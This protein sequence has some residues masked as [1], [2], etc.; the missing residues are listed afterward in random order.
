MTN[1]WTDIRNTD[2]VLAMGGNPA[3][4]HPCGFKW[5]I[6]AKK[7]RRAKLVSVDPRFNRTSA[8]A[9]VYVPI[10]AGT[11]IA[12]LGGLIHH[13]ISN[14]KIHEDYVKLHT[15]ALFLL[16]PGSELGPEGVFGGFDAAT[17][18]YDKSKWKYSLDEKGYAKRAASLDD[19]ACVFQHLKKHFSRYTPE[20][21]AD[22]C[23]CTKEDFLRAA[24]VVNSTGTPDRAGTM[25]YALGWTHHSTSVQIIRA[26]AILQLLLGNIGRA[27]GGVNALRGHAN[28]Q[29]GTDHGVA[30]HSLAGYLKMPHPADTTIDKY[31]ERTTPK[32]LSATSMNYYGNTPKFLVS[33]LKAIYGRNATKE[34]EWGFHWLPKV[35]D[36]YSWVYLFDNMY[37]GKIKGFIDFGMNPVAN[38]PNTEKMIAALARLD[39]CV[40][41]EAF[42]TET[43]DF[44]K[45]TK[46]PSQTEVFLLPAAIFAEKDGSF[47][48]SSR[49]AQWKHKA[50][51]PPGSA[52]ADQEILARLFVRVRE[53]YAKEGGPGAESIS[54]LDWSYK[55]PYDPSLEEIAKEI[56]GRDLGTGK[57][58]SS[59]GE[60]KADGTTA[61]GNWIYSG[62]FTEAGNMMARRDPRDP[63]GLGR[64][65]GWAWNWPANRRVLYNRAGADAEGKPWDPTR[66]GIQWDG[67]KWIGDVPDMKPDAKPGT[68][69]AFVMLPEGVAKL[70]APDFMDGPFPEHYEAQE[71][72]VDNPLHPTYSS[73][74][75]AHVFKSALDPAFGD[76]KVYDIVATTFRL[77]EHFHY[78]TKHIAPNAALQ[79]EFFVEIP[80]GLAKE[81]QIANED[82]VR[83]ST[84]RGSIEGRALV[85]RRLRAMKV[86]GK[87]VWQVAIPIHWGFTGRAGKGVGRG[88]M[89][90]LLTPSVVDPNSHTPEYKTFLVKL[91]KVG[92]V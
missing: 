63:S 3:E 32:P 86:T 12:F 38:G 50:C 19:P 72:P 66:S 26:A 8:V 92:S 68:L 83:L 18:K 2:V 57:Q 89:A 11:D 41:A 84:P 10:R 33:L 34:N 59:F 43:A 28:I 45:V 15:N 56:N 87:T 44:W 85:T 82:R 53:L 22:I 23:G 81:R 71:H 52:L 61:C 24:E 25:M 46:E 51:D 4:N 62:S 9:D 65:E 54:N 90:N 60:L 48:N 6:E 70:W 88:P 39:W 27:G 55:N 64:Y 77:T 47:S 76:P 40:I 31:L 5:V 35:A 42:E 91:E 73:N 30:Y 1:G 80:E 7:K 37:A 74:P 79:P 20:V 67:D 16:E 78:W 69:D 49:W 21:V 36:N 75:V 13:A 17:K 58:L 14:Q 29:G